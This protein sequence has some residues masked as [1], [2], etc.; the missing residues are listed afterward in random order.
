MIAGV[1]DA[2]WR[3]YQVRVVLAGPTAAV[4]RVTI[5]DESSPQA[6]TQGPIPVASTVFDQGHA[7]PTIYLWL[8]S[9]ERL[10]ASRPG[11]R[12]F[13]EFPT[14]AQS[15]RLSRILGVSLAHEIAHYLLDSAFHSTRGLL[16]ATMS[17]L[18]MLDPRLKDLGLDDEQIAPLCEKLP[19]LKNHDRP[20]VGDERQ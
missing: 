13:S 18:Q 8:G 19:A 6:G 17:T 16:P 10:A 12:D 11:E 4:L 20:H 15:L 3:R 9:A 1:T 2:V 7:T 5:A 14:N